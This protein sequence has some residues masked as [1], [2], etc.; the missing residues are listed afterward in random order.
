MKGEAAN[1]GEVT[2]NSLYDYIAGKWEAI[3]SGR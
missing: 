1:K 3:G 2:V